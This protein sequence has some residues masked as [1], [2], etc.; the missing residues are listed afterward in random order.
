MFGLRGTARRELAGDDPAI[1]DELSRMRVC[2]LF[3]LGGLD[4]DASATTSCTMDPTA[5]G[6]DFAERRP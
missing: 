4:A 5:I 1:S 3:R 2:H 6:I